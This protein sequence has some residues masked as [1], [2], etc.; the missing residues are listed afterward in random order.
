NATGR[1]TAQDD[2]GTVTVSYSD[3]VTNL[4][5]GTKVIARTWTALD[6]CGNSTNAV[7]TIVVQDITPPTLTTPSSLTLECPANTNPTNTGVATAQD[8]CGAVTVSFSDSGRNNCGGARSIART[9]RAPEPC[10]NP[11]TGR[12]T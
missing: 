7:Q 10:S 6:Y 2:C 12:Q 11:T 9:W 1:A 5:A 8:G 3:S 4:C